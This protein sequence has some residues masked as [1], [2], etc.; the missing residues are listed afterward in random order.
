MGWELAVEMD[1]AYRDADDDHIMAVA[2]KYGA[3]FAVLFNETATALPVLF[4]GNHYKL[5][6]LD[7]G[8]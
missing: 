1:R 7:E 5:V 2:S 6:A 4:T 3:T 8:A